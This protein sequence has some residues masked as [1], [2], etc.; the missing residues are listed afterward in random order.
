M[1]IVGVS[2]DEPEVNQ[3]WAEEEGFSFDLWTDDDR[4]LALAYGAATSASQ[5]YASR[6]T[7]ILDAEGEL[8]LVYDSV[9][10][11]AHPA[12]VLEDCQIL[13]GP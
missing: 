9:S 8:V 5:P 4:T 10:V 2:F 12:D 13:F 1:Q 6:K 3:A 11:S 7:V